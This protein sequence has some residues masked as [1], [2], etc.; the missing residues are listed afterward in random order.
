[1]RKV[2]NEAVYFPGCLGEKMTI[3]ITL[4]SLNFLQAVLL[5]VCLG[6]LYDGFRGVRLVFRTGWVVNALLDLLFWAVTAAAFSI[7]VLTAARGNCR[8]YLLVG[9]GLG[10][11]FYELT[12]SLLVQ[13]IFIGMLQILSL[14]CKK[15][16]RIGKCLGKAVARLS[17][18]KKN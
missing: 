4:Q 2:G 7:F 6:I 5:G 11:L 10:I 18:L 13:Q 1:M 12:V 17:F 3:S 9:L 15:I 16:G 14:F 8:L